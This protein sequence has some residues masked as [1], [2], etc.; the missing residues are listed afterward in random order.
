M[1]AVIN[2]ECRYGECRGAG[3][4]PGDKE[5]FVAAENNRNFDEA[6]GSEHDNTKWGGM[7]PSRNREGIKNKC[8]NR[9]KWLKTN[10][11]LFTP[12]CSKLQC[13]CLVL[14]KV[15]LVLTTLRAG[16]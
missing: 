10:F 13:Q 1:L 11:L 9:R 12:M 16:I 4:G 5:P 15:G 14:I 3:P 7:P 8:Q 2:A 6:I